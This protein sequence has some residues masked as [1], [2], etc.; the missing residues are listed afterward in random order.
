MSDTGKQRPD[1]RTD[2]ATRGGGGDPPAH[3]LPVDPEF[4][5]D[6]NAPADERVEVIKRPEDLPESQP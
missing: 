2:E 6:D 4:P 3:E 5:G 1:D